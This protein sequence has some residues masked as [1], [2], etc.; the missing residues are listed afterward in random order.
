MIIFVAIAALILGG[1]LWAKNNVSEIKKWRGGNAW[2]LTYEATSSRGEPQ[3]A[4][5]SYRHNPDRSKADHKNVRL[6]PTKLP[7]STEVL[8][9]TGQEA[10][11]EVAPTGNGTV[12]CRILLDGIRVVA[13]AKS[14]AP[15][16]PAVC[17]VTTSSTPEK[18]PR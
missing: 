2:Y 4:T 13:T 16:K 9:N 12:S 1:M 6:G 15:G 7:W 14:P 3:N 10:R 11:V 18:W 5:L 8:V 17:H